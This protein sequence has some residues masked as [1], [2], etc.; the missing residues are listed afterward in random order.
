[1]AVLGDVGRV[2]KSQTETDRR[3]GRNGRITQRVRSGDRH[4]SG[5][6]TWRPVVTMRAGSA[7]VG[8]ICDAIRDNS[9]AG[10]KAV[11]VGKSGRCAACM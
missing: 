6:L 9:F 10:S 1:M 3:G 8:S 7:R 5:V 11:T 4:C 2:L